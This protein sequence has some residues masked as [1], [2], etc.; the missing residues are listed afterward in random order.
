MVTKRRS[1]V[2]PNAKKRGR[3]AAN[4]VCSCGQPAT[5]KA[6]VAMYSIGVPTGHSTGSRITKSSTA[7][8]VCGDCIGRKPSG[9]MPKLRTALSHA[10]TEAAGKISLA[11]K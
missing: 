11:N 4:T 7:F 9:E 5:H 3:K 2:N 6:F 10:Y 1:R 8:G